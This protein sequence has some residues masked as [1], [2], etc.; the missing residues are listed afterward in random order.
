MITEID[1]FQ[2]FKWILPLAYSVTA[3][4]LFYILAID[5]FL[6]CH[7]LLRFSHGLHVFSRRPR[8]IILLI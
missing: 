7:Q 8:L 3:V 6:N 2:C 1:I 5:L 4:F